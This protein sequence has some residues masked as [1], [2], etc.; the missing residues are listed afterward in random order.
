MSIKTQANVQQHP[1]LTPGYAV[2]FGEKE[3]N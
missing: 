3:T 2:G 1:Q